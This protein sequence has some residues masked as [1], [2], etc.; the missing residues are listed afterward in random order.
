MY[1]LHFICVA[2]L[3]VLHGRENKTAVISLKALTGW[4]M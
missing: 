4:S 2:S 3:S 1:H